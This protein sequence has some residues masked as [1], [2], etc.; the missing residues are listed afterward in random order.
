VCGQNTATSTD[1]LKC[2][3]V[4]VTF[5]NVTLWTWHL[6]CHVVGRL[7]LQFM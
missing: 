2:D 3:L 5:W 6:S 4:N 7:P 1:I